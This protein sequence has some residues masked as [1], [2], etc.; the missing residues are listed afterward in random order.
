MLRSL[1]RKKVGSAVEIDESIDL[2]ARAN[3]AKGQ[4]E[5]NFLVLAECLFMIVRSAS[6]RK[7]GYKSFK[8]YVENELDFQPRKATYLVSVW[9]MVVSYDLPRDR[10][11]K[12]KWYKAA[13]LLPVLHD[14]NKELWLERA[15]QMS[16]AE[17]ERAVKE[18]QAEMSGFEHASQIVKLM[19]RL[20]TADASL[21]AD[22][23][24]KSKEINETDNG[25]VALARICSE[26][27]V[28]K[29]ASLSAASADYYIDYIN[30]TFGL[31]I[32]LPKE[33]P[34][35]K[36]SKLIPNVMDDERKPRFVPI[37]DDDIDSVLGLNSDG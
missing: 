14:E 11:E 12:I 19:F 28:M 10:I 31:S 5:H 17:L 24:E 34:P 3:E 13:L 6:Y 1:R 29:G 27:L 2:R 8:A 33:T 16:T 32:E 15:E 18:Y 7:W 37:T 35:Q 4:I 26:W 21:V 36:K 25:G 20:D 23:V 30:K 9:N 22:A